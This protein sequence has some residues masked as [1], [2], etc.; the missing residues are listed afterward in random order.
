MPRRRNCQ[1]MYEVIEE[2]EGG[3]KRGRPKDFL[4]K[5]FGVELKLGEEK[6]LESQYEQGD[7]VC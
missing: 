1:P 7:T 4:S 6:E 2:R 5:A 3:R